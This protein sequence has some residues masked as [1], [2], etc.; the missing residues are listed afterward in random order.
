[1]LYLY[2]LGFFRAQQLQGARVVAENNNEAMNARV[3]ENNNIQNQ[4]EAVAAGGADRPP[5]EEGSGGAEAPDPEPDRP[6]LFALTWTFFTSF[7][8]SLI[9]EQPGAL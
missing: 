7:F 9:P 2:Q 6:S 5:R 1:M 3:V 8:A 4:D